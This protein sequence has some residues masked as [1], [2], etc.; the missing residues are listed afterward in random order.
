MYLVVLATD[1][2]SHVRKPWTMDLRDWPAL[3][4]MPHAH[5]I[6]HNLSGLT[7][8]IWI[9]PGTLDPSDD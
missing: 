8:C 1:R 4:L 2:S 5:R 7:D 3:G 6:G 9:A